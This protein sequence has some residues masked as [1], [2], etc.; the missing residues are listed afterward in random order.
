MSEPALIPLPPLNGFVAATH[1]PLHDDGS[2]NLAAVEI[3]AAHLLRNRVSK[4]F[5]GGSTGEY[6]SLS[7]EERLAL[8]QRWVEVAR[9]TS[10]VIVVHVGSNCLEDARALARNA[11]RHRAAAIAAVAPSYFKPRD[12]ATLVACCAHIAS[13]APNTPFYYYDIPVLTGVSLSMLGFLAQAR[14]AIPTLAG[15]KFSNPD[16][17]TYQ[18]LRLADGGPWE[19]LW[20][21]DEYMLA[22]LALGAKGF[23]GST[24]NFAAPIYHRL[25]GAFERGDLEA[26]REE[27]LRSA[28]LVQL[29]LASGFMGASKVVMGMLGVKVGPARLPHQNPT[30]EQRTKLRAELAALGFFDWIGV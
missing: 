17:H 2:V 27:Q 15:I 14:G 16:L 11:Q 8:T 13:A 3:Q 28:Q 1:T 30:P 20:G 10:L 9:G 7:L 18:L 19:L 6:S 29:L 23:V 22:A 26:A 12:T 21:I 25:I 5:I 4:V 24:Y